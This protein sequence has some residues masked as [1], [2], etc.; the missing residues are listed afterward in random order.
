MYHT[1][2]FRYSIIYSPATSLQV[3]TAR[4]LRVAANQFG[5]STPQR[6]AV[7]KVKSFIQLLTVCFLHQLMRTQLARLVKICYSEKLAAAQR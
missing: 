5:L 7:K 1:I 3:F 2:Q 4:N 6:M